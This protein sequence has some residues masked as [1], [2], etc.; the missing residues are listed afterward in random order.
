MNPLPLH[1][2]IMVERMKKEKQESERKVY[3]IPSSWRK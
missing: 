2:I 3:S 1:N